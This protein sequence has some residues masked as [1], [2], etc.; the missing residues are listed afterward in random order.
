MWIFWARGRLH[1]AQQS[2]QQSDTRSQLDIASSRHASTLDGSVACAWVALDCP[3]MLCSLLHFK[4]CT[5][6]V[7]GLERVRR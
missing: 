2:F 7:G 1:M 5:P 4:H 6:R 3:K